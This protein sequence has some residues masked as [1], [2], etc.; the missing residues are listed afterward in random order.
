MFFLSQIKTNHKRGGGEL[1]TN[2]IR[3]LI[4]VDNLDF[5]LDVHSWSSMSFGK[6]HKKKH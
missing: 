5:D 1:L 6:L 2:E 3:M 4:H